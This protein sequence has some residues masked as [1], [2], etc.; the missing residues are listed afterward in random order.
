MFLPSVSL[1]F[2]K[3]DTEPFVVQVRETI[4]VDYFAFRDTCNILFPILKPHSR[5]V[6]VSSF[7]GHLSHIPG[8]HLREI[9]SSPDLTEKQLSEVISSYVK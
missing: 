1:F 8:K 2:Q 7:F 3:E 5:V 4:R 9:L 6:N